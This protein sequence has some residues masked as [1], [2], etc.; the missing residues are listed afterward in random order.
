MLQSII[1]LLIFFNY[2]KYSKPFLP[3]TPYKNRWWAGLAQGPGL[4]T[5]G[6]SHYWKPRKWK[7]LW[8]AVIN[9]APPSPGGLSSEPDQRPFRNTKAEGILS[10]HIWFS[11]SGKQLRNVHLEMASWIFFLCTAVSKIEICC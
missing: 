1:L 5:P 4:L 6:L 8:D 11:V 9:P 10:T 3:H 7:P 2:L